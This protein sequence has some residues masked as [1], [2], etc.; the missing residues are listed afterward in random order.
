MRTRRPRTPPASR[1]RCA[2]AASSAGS[3]RA[4]RSVIRPSAA[5]AARSASLSCCVQVVA[6]PDR[7]NLDRALGLAPERAHRGELAAVAHGGQRERAHHGGID[8]R[9]RAVTRWRG[10]SRRPRRGRRGGRPRRRRDRGPARS[11]WARRRRYPQPGHLGQLDRVPADRAR[12]PGDREGLPR[13]EPEQVQ[14]EPGGQPVHRQR[15]RLGQADLVGHRHHRVGRHH[16]ELGLGSAAGRSAATRWPSPGRPA[17]TRIRAEAASIVPASSMP[18]TYGGSSPPARRARPVRARCR[19]GSRS[20][21]RPGSAPRRRR[22]RAPAARR[23]GDLRPAELGDAYRSH[24]VLAS[25]LWGG[26]SSSRS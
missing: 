10:G 13:R 8:E 18:G 7:D 21:P 20:P 6:D 5:R 23:S 26:W 2:S 4:T 9:V 25:G 17:G 3:V 11:H 22:A 1:R 14:G 19:S 24:V 12:G 15:G 16:H